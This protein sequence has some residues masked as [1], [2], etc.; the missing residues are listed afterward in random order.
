MNTKHDNRNMKNG[1]AIFVSS[2]DAYSD[3]WSPFFE[4]FFRYWPDCPFPVYLIS[5][6]KSYPDSRVIMIGIDPDQGWAS[7]MLCVLATHPYPYL[8]YLQEDYFLKRLVD[9]DRILNLLSL[10]KREHAACLKLYPAPGPDTFYKN[11]R[12]VGMIS[13][14]MPYRVSLQAGFW[15][16]NVF[17][18]LLVVG[19]RGVDMEYRGNIRSVQLKEPFLS[20]NRGIFFPY[21]KSA[22]IDYFAT[23]IIKNRWHVG[24]PFFFKKE[25]IVGNLSQREVEPPSERFRHVAKSLPLIAPLFRLIFRIEY[26]IWTI[27]RG[28]FH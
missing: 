8:L 2:C 17:R 21:D 23:G 5:N 19:E 28:N 3:A 27:I 24:I 16:T 7:N 20:V 4:L 11:Y 14:G 22:A 26:K 6:K 12:E 1:C 13:P 18:Q 9:T 25:G 15:D 10:L